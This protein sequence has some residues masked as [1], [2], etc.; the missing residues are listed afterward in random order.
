M[1][2]ANLHIDF[3]RLFSLPFLNPIVILCAYFFCFAKLRLRRHWRLLFV[4]FFVIVELQF[5]CFAVLGYLCSNVKFDPFFSP[6][7]IIF[8]SSYCV[9]SSRSISPT[10][11]D[12]GSTYALSVYIIW[13]KKTPRSAYKYAYIQRLCAQRN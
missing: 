3:V 2:A 5:V 12:V 9:P 6:L 8:S 7:S 11:C 4:I 13:L 1:V 10:A